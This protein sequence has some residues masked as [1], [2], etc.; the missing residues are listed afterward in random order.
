MAVSELGERAWEIY[1][2][3]RPEVETP[4]NIGKMIII[5]TESGD[6]EIDDMGIESAHRLYERH[7]EAKLFGLRIGYNAVD[8]FGGVLERLPQ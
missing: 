7:P 3:I 1:Y 5:D 2:R 8:T 4:D 6:Y